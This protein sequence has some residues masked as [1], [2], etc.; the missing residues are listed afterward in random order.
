MA[1]CYWNLYD[2][3]RHITLFILLPLG[4]VMFLR[5]LY[6]LTYSPVGMTDFLH[7]VVGEVSDK[8]VQSEVQ[9]L[10]AKLAAAEQ[11]SQSDGTTSTLKGILDNI[12]FGL[13]GLGD[14]NFGDQ[15]SKLQEGADAKQMEQA[16]ISDNSS[17]KIAGMDVE[18]LKNQAAQTMKEIYPIMEF[19]DKVMKAMQQGIDKIPGASELLENLTGAMQIFVFSILAPYVK[20]IL[21]RVK[22][23]LA[24]GSGG[25]LQAS[26][27]AQFVVFDDGNSSDPTHS[28][29]SK[30]HFTNLLNPVAGRVASEAVKFATPLIVSAWEDTN[31]DPNQICDEILQVFHHPALRDEG[32]QG[33]RAMFEAVQSWWNEKDEHAKEH[34]KEALSKEGV[35]EGK[36]HEGDDPNPGPG[37]CGH[38]HGGVK[39][40]AGSSGQ[41]QN[42]GI[43]ER[44]QEE[45]S[46]G[47]GG[48]YNAPSRARQEETS[49][50]GG[51]GGEYGSSNRNREETSSYGSGGG[52]GSS[53]REETS[54]Y[55]R[56]GGG[57]GSSN[58]R[59]GDNDSYDSSTRHRN[60][61]EDTSSYGQ[62][63][64]DYSGS[65]A[66]HWGGEDTSTP[67][68]AQ[69]TSN[70]EESSYSSR[71]EDTSS[72]RRGGEDE[73][74]S[75][76]Q[77]TS[78]YG[79]D[80]Q[81]SHETS[82]RNLGDNSYS[83]STRQHR[84]GEEETSSYGRSRDNE[85]SSYGRDREETSSYGRN[86]DD[87]TS[88]YGHNRGDETSSYGRN[89]DNETSSYGRETSSYNRDDQ[90]PS[91]YGHQ[92]SSHG[93]GG[94]N[95]TS[96]YGRDNEGTS[97]YGRR[98]GGDNEEE[99]TGSYGRR[100][101]GGE[102]EES[103]GYGGSG[104][105][106]GDRY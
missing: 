21:L 44:G 77:G 5:L 71:N 83:P 105:Y 11:Q 93:R 23:E 62:N 63:T 20:P 3:L 36:N 4:F 31:R 98:R 45:S 30:D 65:S 68:S 102:E 74:P 2:P 69:R 25:V 16:S 10:D 35:R 100:H 34:L 28:V 15:A 59:R 73:T 78:S 24:A 49:S 48:G 32:R 53:N 70:R 95:E 50:Y 46:Y 29:L 22:T 13:L 39:R 38:S 1:S 37:G 92:T 56:G 84:N 85:T 55:G 66:R 27:N 82:T 17:T 87:E 9:D 81:A 90:E 64:E 57:Y 94:G 86:R 99:E 18:Q 58:T 41:H 91:G 103:G 89:R 88:S 14:S 26:E 80:H 76:G 79:R 7:S 42:R 47:G 61:D 40:A 106:S 8:V 72:Y 60:N 52:Y 104:G 67:Y 12:P 33:Q 6:D 75:F 96:S 19:H 97:G 101:R 51:G 43:G 54:S